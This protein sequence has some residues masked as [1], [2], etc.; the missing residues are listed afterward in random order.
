MR[1]IIR[2]WILLVIR[3]WNKN[4]SMQFSELDTWCYF[5]LSASGK[6]GSMW[7]WDWS[8]SG[9]CKSWS[10]KMRLINS[11]LDQFRIL[12]LSF[13]KVLNFDY[14]LWFQVWITHCF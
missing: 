2:A 12:T 5:M 7:K 13:F 9:L 6:W 11:T 3:A 10:V 8:F 4:F 1:E 14:I